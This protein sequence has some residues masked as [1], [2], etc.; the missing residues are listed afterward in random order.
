[1]LHAVR[2]SPAWPERHEGIQLAGHVHSSE[3]DACNQGMQHTCFDRVLPARDLAEDSHKHG[4]AEFDES[5]TNT[6]EPMAADQFFRSFSERE[7]SH[8]AGTALQGM[9]ICFTSLSC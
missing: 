2:L 9:P 4:I 8:A 1:M 5:M 7:L 3:Q 6:K